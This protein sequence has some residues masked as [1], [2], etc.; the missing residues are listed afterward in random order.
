MGLEPQACTTCAVASLP[1][2]ACANPLQSDINRSWPPS[3]P[4]AVCPP[5]ELV[6]YNELYDLVEV[7]PLLHEVRAAC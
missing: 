2:T 3:L 6:D 5:Y 4:P 1:S 7:S